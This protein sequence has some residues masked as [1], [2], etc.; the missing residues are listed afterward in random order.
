MH[1]YTAPGWARTIYDVSGK[2][3]EDFGPGP[4]QLKMAWVTI[5][6]KLLP[7]FIIYG[8]MV[9]CDNF[10]TAAWVYLGLHGVGL[11]L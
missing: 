8:M 4:K 11:W 10:S 7:C 5:F 9:H 2:L 6:T 1:K 3:T